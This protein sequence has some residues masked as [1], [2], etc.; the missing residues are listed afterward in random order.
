MNA[1]SEKLNSPKWQRNRLEI[2]ERDGFKCGSCKS[3]DKTLHV[4]HWK[5]SGNP[6]E[7][8]NADLQTLC[9]DCHSQVEE[10]ISILKQGFGG[11][12]LDSMKEI[13]MWDR[14]SN[15]GAMVLRGLDSSFRIFA[16]IQ[17]D[18]IKTAEIIIEELQHK[19]AK[20]R[21]LK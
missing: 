21:A 13:L 19:I 15:G 2:M 8:D 18:K 17:G 20:W 10:S 6:W 11:F 5:Y 1:Y 3:E 16:T 14:E 4:H 9:E 7:S 12:L